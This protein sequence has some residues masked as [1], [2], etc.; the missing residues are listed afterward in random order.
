MTGTAE[1]HAT[2]QRIA[3]FSAGLRGHLLGEWRMAEDYG[4]ASCTRC[5]AELRVY[6]PALYPEMEGAALERLCDP[7]SAERAA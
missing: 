5:G 2:L 7:K 1:R 3:V 6:L 4:R